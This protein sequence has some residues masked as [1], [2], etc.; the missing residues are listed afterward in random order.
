MKP[1]PQPKARI[2]I[3]EDE[4]MI[5]LDLEDMLADADFEIA[6]VAASVEKALQFIDSRVFDFAVLDV[7]LGGFSARP[8]ALALLACGVPYV[9]MSGYSTGQQPV[10]L[11]NAVLLTKPV[12]PARIIQA[13]RNLLR[14]R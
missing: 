5:A 11:R 13:L 8:A 9:V 10:V 2:L 6:G 7:N 1:G 4:P 3:V 12:E 14:V